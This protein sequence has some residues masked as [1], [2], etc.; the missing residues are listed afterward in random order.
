MFAITINP[1]TLIGIIQIALILISILLFF[2]FPYIMMRRVSLGNKN[3]VKNRSF[4]PNVKWE[5]I[6]D[7]E[8]VK[9]RLEEIAENVK[10]G[11]AYGVIL[12]GPP[13]TGKTTMAKGLANKLKWNYFELKPSSILSKWYGESEFLLDQFFNQV[14]ESA[15]A[16]VFIDELDS[17]ALSRQS[18]IHEVT[19]RLV[20]IMLM[21]LQDLHDK[22]LPVLIIGATNVPQ[23][24]DEA[25]L[26]PGRFDEVIY[27]P[28]PDESGRE[29]IWKGLLKIDGINYELLAKKSERFSPADI[30]NV[31]DEVNRR[32]KNPT[33]QDILSLIE[34]YKPSIPISTIIRF[35]TI[36]R[37]YSR[38][39]I[40]LKLYGIPEITWNDIGDM[41][42]IKEEIRKSIELPII[43]RDIAE[44]LNV[45][46]IKGLL[47]YGPPGTGKTTVAKALANELKANF[48]EL[49]GEEVASAG[50]FNAPQ[51][52]AEKFYVAIDNAPAVIFIDEIDMI[53]KNRL[54]NEWRDALTEL[55]RQ[56]DGLRENSNVIVIGATNRPWDLDPA[57]LR[58]GRFDKIIYVPPPNRE[59]REKIL[60]VLTRGLKV[61][62]E[63][64]KKVSEMTEN[65]T[66]ADLKLVIEEIKRKLLVEASN[67]NNNVRIEITL[68]DFLEV[69]RRIKPSVTQEELKL[70]ENYR[71]ERR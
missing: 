1:N 45:K 55:L 58:P 34:S 7:Q 38:T 26:R 2:L 53:A 23:E 61:D 11:K 33:T 65:F 10:S 30:K 50:P 59:A 62:D 51:I 63:T 60:R 64:I 48:I 56:M 44:K 41:E 43:K 27:V 24:I 57:I 3:K 54:G 36:A 52:I 8:K 69:L 5:E 9:T 28:L 37:K 20:N 29:K 39:K 47:L 70:Y 15:P 46:P 67:N 22:G 35:E 12:F 49:S 13:G 32:F 16:I 42:D 14:E 66:P 4:V 68:E 6:Y 19:H 71:L 25:F 21:R 31:V 18:D 17:L 40:N